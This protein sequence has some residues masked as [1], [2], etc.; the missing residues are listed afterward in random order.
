[1]R[2]WGSPR[3]G[4]WRLRITHRTGVDY[5]GA[6][7]SSYNE[8]RMTPQTNPHQA[9]LEAWVDVEPDGSSYRYWDYWG[10]Q[11]T[12]FDRQAPHDR[13][14][15]VATAVVETFADDSLDE[16]RLRWPDLADVAVAD[17]F[18]EFLLET[19]RTALNPELQHHADRIRCEEPTPGEA[20]LAACRLVNREVRYQTGA[21]GVHTRAVDAWAERIGVCQDLSHLVV[22]L[23]RGM[24]IPARYVSGYLH[25]KPNAPIGETVRGQSHAWVEWW[26][27]GWRGYDPTNS[28]P[29]GRQHVVIGRGRDYADVSPL[30]GVYA[31]P[32]STAHGVEVE[33][34]R[35]R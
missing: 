31:G 28:K 8:A 17:E 2:S 22:G 3:E 34:T 9:V 1:M 20:A 6:V 27:G 16:P 33:V 30:K 11:V 19:P 7:T 26:D 25:P 13:L 5:A 24:G 18:D 29:L 21:T 4:S 12:A 15:V 10:T 35:L 14:T 32:K 23:I